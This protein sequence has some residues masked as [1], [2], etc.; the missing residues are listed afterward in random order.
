[1]PLRVSP[2]VFSAG[3]SEI[4]LQMTIQYRCRLV[5]LPNNR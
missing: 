2:L 5:K 1:M 3:P 4:D